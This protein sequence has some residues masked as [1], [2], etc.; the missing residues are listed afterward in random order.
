MY[1]FEIECL[2]RSL[3]IG[4][5]YRGYRYLSYGVKLC[6]CD[7]EYLLS[8][9]KLLYPEIAR[10]FHATRSSVERDIRTVI[11]VCW[12]RGNRPYLQEIAL[13]PLECKPTTGEFF[14]ILVSYI[15]R[16][17]HHENNAVSPL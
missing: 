12:D 14:D 1:D 15:G 6:V 2:I 4:A 17:V 16:A 3:G 13:H 9:S 8:I 11:K 10:Q 5:T 7:E